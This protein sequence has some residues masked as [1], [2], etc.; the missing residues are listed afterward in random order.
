[1]ENDDALTLRTSEQ[2]ITSSNDAV[3][4]WPRGRVVLKLIEEAV[5]N[6]EMNIRTT[7]QIAMKG[8]TT[9]AAKP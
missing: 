4:A 6:H 7:K 1:M 2:R 3:N 5:R 9:G 8:R